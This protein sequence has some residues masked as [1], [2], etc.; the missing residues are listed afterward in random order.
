MDN[1]KNIYLEIECEKQVSYPH[2]NS[3]PTTVTE[4]VESREQNNLPLSKIM[5]NKKEF[6]IS[7]PENEP[8]KNIKYNGDN[9]RNENK[10]IKLRKKDLYKILKMSKIPKDEIDPYILFSF[11][12][13]KSELV[14]SPVKTY[15]IDYNNLLNTIQ[16]FYILFR[17]GDGDIEI[18]KDSM[19]KIFDLLGISPNDRL[20]FLQFFEVDEEIE[21]EEEENEEEKVDEN[22]LSKSKNRVKVNVITKQNNFGPN[23]IFEM[24]KMTKT[25]TTVYTEVD[26][27]KVN[28]KLKNSKKIKKDDIYRF[29]NEDLDEKVIRTKIQK[30]KII[31][32]KNEKL[33]KPEKPEP[34]KTLNN[35]SLIKYIGGNNNNSEK[36]EPSSLDELKKVIKNIP[37]IL[38]SLKTNNS[39]ERKKSKPKQNKLV[40][41]MSKEKKTL[42]PNKTEEKKVEV[43]IIEINTEINREINNYNNENE[44]ENESEIDNFLNN[45]SLEISK[46]TEEK[47]SKK[48]NSYKM[49][50]GS[51]RKKNISRYTFILPKSFEYDNSKMYLSGSIP[52]LG[53][54]NK[55]SAIQMDEEIKNGQ[56]FYIKY[57]D[58][59]KED[60]P[61]EYKYFYIK[62]GK[63]QWIGKPKV[64]Y[65]S[66]R[67]YSNLYET[68]QEKKDILSLFDLN[69]RYLNKVDGLNIWDNRKEKLMEVIL[70]YLPDILFFQEIT[71]TQ[72]E[73]ME[74]NLNS[75]YENVGIYRDNTDRSEK[76]SIMYNK[77]KYTLTDWGQ[78]WLSST[79]Y[80]PGS[81]D[82]GNFFPRICTWALLRQMNG[83]QFLFFNIHLDH[84]NF[85]AHLPCINVVIN[86]SEKVLRNFPDTKMVFLGGCFYCEE[87]DELIGKLKEFGYNEVMFENTFHD[88][89]GD[90]DRHW[91]YMFWR[92]LN[93]HDN[94]TII[95]LK[96]SFVLKED[97]I[98]N[99]RNQQYISDHY[100]VI[101]EFLVESRVVKKNN[102]LLDEEEKNINNDYVEDEE[103]DKNINS[104]LIYDQGDKKDFS[105][106]DEEETLKK[107]RELE[108]NEN[109]M[110]NFKLKEE[111]EKKI[112]SYNDNNNE[113]DEENEEVEVIEVEEEIEVNDEKDKEKEKEKDENKEEDEEEK[114]DN[115]NKE[116]EE[117]EKEDNKEE[118]EEEKEDKK[119]ENDENDEDKKSNKKGNEEEEEV[120][121]IEI[122]QEEQSE[123]K[124]K[125]EEGEDAQEQEEE[126]EEE[127]EEELEEENNE[128]DE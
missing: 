36:L 109:N 6:Y 9:I 117:E 28:Y 85:D 23:A 5:P 111:K 61:F 101:A 42:K 98:I 2:N 46:T 99:L 83:E 64:N 120:E 49:S 34:E 118:N 55:D 45:N 112:Y 57:I 18:S 115:D 93:V 69:I 86:E 84:A 76:C 4:V 35:K 77:I 1:Q 105:E 106:L 82:F 92:E 16:N 7:F 17:D 70:K 40:K 125:S 81:N 30:T 88:F 41:K 75:V 33:E 31:Q 97:S 124:D 11:T 72:Y 37:T 94:N 50:P 32:E 48:F 128:E 60:F 19:N 13:I 3:I 10:K 12:S 52:L 66:H 78:F 90:A 68:I 89:A 22:P 73:Y 24:E 123:K 108:K 26:N 103:E 14:S 27:E 39:K 74:D 100:P 8:Q 53:N 121:E 96:R 21:Y 38:K 51:P 54:W 122:E 71:R 104:E 114:E 59:N 107:S 29:D 67:Q 127:Q 102:L 80:T 47:N 63:T 126:K 87:D 110:N 65:I 44:Y 113:D 20:K 91:D 43:K 56:Q 116:D 62:N 58:I 95:K 119:D 79:P 15:K 25:T